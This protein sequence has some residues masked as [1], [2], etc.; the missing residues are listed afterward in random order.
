[1]SS[2]KRHDGYMVIDQRASGDP[3]P[4]LEKAGSFVELNTISCRH[5]GGVWRENPFRLRA[6]E[7]CRTCNMY[8][9]D[10]CYARSKQPDYIHRTIDDLTEMVKSGRYIIAGGTSSDPI[11]IRTGVT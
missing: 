3:I 8:Q 5:C 7:Y 4:G 1:M 11:L 6:R 9:C 10:G 2:L